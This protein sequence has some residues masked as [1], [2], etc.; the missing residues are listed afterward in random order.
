MQDRVFPMVMDCENLKFNEE[1][2]DAVYG[3]AI[4]HHLNL[5]KGL[6][7]IWR[8]LKQNGIGVFIEPLAMNPFINFYRMMTP[9][10]RTPYEKPLD[11]GDFKTINNAH[12]SN[13]KHREFTLL[14]N[15]G[16]FFN[17]VLKISKGSDASYERLKRFDDLVLSKFHFLRR[18]CWNTVLVM[19]K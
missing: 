17:S 18:F 16:I 15:L 4:L 5:R 9:G 11:K 19:I 14:C 13:V 1:E 7:E 6:Q 3:R 8:V 2:F 10:R 12:F